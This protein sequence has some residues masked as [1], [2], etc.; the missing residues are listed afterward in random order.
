MIGKSSLLF[1]C[2]FFLFGRCAKILG[3][4][5]SP[6]PSHH[7]SFKAISW[8]LASKGHDVTV[9]SPN[10]LNVTN[11]R[12]FRE[13]DVHHVYET[14]KLI[15]AFD[16]MSKDALHISKCFGYSLM[17]RNAIEDVF[18]NKEVQQI[19]QNNDTYDLL[20]VQ[21]TNPLAFAFTSLF[22]VP[23][24]GEFSLYMTVYLIISYINYITE[25]LFLGILSTL[26]TAA[27]R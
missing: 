7:E 9:I 21:A 24:V 11:M 15:K 26:P 20:L 4:F 6:S 10:I 2:S 12:N 25:H 14:L 23:V 8:E 19:L 13:I 18:S 1:L 22:K 3:F 17:M 27:F 16:F 5:A